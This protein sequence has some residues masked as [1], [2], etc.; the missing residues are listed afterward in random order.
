MARHRKNNIS[1]FALLVL[2]LVLIPLVFF[3][4]LAV[5]TKLLGSTRNSLLW[6]GGLG[7][8]L[9]ASYHLYSWSTWAL[10][11]FTLLSLGVTARQ[12]QLS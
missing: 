9:V 5:G 11:V 7:F 10:I 12:A 8:Y 4:V 3:G 6:L 2:H 1:S